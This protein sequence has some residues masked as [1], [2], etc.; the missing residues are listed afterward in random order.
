MGDAGAGLILSIIGSYLTLYYTDSVGLSAAFAGTMMLVCRIFDGV[1]DILMGLLIDNTHTRIGKARPWF[2]ISFVPLTLS[3]LACFFVPANLSDPG[4]K[5]YAIAT[6]FLMSV[7]FYTVN[8]IAYHAMLQR[9]SLTSQDRSS[10]SAVRSMITVT[11]CLVAGIATPLYLGSHDEA[12]QSTWTGIIMAYA[13]ISTVFLLL[14]AIGIKEKLPG[15]EDFKQHHRTGNSKE[16][17]KAVLKTRYFWIAAGVSIFYFTS[18]NLTGMAYYF[19]RDV[20]HNGAIQSIISLISVFPMVLGA[21][22]AVMLI[23]RLGKRKVL[24]CGLTISVVASLMILI[25]PENVVLV[26]ASTFIKCLGIVPIST[27]ATT[28]AGDI[29]D[30]VQMKDG[31]RSE[32]VTTSTYTVGVKIGA[33]LGSAI[34]AWALAIGKYDGAASVQAPS[35]L[36]A[37][38][39]TTAVVP[40]VLYILC[41]VLL[42]FWDIEKYQTEVQQYMRQQ[43]DNQTFLEENL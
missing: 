43:M 28:L 19:A 24:I 13:V 21:P 39:V 37:M 42:L 7:V 34:V 16:A 38:T 3:F 25:D 1:S 33:G 6:Y 41:I 10:V 26:L 12:L 22:F 31:V 5:V 4:K 30:Y 29:A 15:N 32:G 20:M 35:A 36:T 23:N 17:V 14:T 2:L 9:F 40:A 27:A 8:N 18:S 11:I